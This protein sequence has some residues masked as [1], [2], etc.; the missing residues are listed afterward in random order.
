VKPVPVFTN[1]FG[2][3]IRVP[4]GKFRLQ[5]LSDIHPKELT[6]DSGDGFFAIGAFP[7]FDLVG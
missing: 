3:K 1:I 7:I 6:P 4:P 2:N 5:L